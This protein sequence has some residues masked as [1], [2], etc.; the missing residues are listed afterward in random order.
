SPSPGRS[1]L[2]YASLFLSPADY[3][4]I[5]AADPPVSMTRLT[6]WAIWRHRILEQNPEGLVPPAKLALLHR[7]VLEACDARD[8]VKDG[9]L[10]DPRRCDFDPGALQCKDA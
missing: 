6:A 9:I 8:G 5:I 3:H 1:L 4:G 10:E 7:A 2:P